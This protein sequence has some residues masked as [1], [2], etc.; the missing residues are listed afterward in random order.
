MRW[1][2]SAEPDSTT[3]AVWYKRGRSVA[4]SLVEL[5]SCRASSFPPS[6]LG[7]SLRWSGSPGS[8]PQGGWSEDM[9]CGGMYCVWHSTYDAK[10]AGNANANI[11]STATV[12]WVM[13]GQTMGSLEICMRPRTGMGG[14]WR[15]EWRSLVPDWRLETGDMRLGEGDGSLNFGDA[16]PGA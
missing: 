14:V 9:G 12:E 6:S 5:G 4:L 13:M 7:S 10:P 15:R 11:N 8:T 16:C 3:Q 2:G 1:V